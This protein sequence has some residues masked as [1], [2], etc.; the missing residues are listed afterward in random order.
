VSGKKTYLT[1]GIMIAAVIANQLGY[2]EDKGLAL[3]LQIG[4]ISSAAFIRSAIQ[5]GK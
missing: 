2:L 1:V 3:I 4:G 5:K